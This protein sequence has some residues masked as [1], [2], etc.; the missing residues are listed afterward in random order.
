MSTGN[1][2]AELLAEV[3]EMGFLDPGRYREAFKK[4]PDDAEAQLLASFRTMGPEARQL[5][6]EW[7]HD[8]KCVEAI[9]PLMRYVFDSRDSPAQDGPRRRA[10]EAIRAL[11]EHVS[12][13]KLQAFA[14]DMSTDS[15]AFVREEVLLILGKLGGRRSAEVIQRA[16]DDKEPKVRQRARLLM[17]ELP[18]MATWPDPRLQEMSSERVL[19][20]VRRTRN[21]V[22]RRELLHFLWCREDGRPHLEQLLKEGGRLAR[23]VLHVLGRAAEPEAREVVAN[24]LA[25]LPEGLN[26][27][28]A[29]NQHIIKLGEVENVVG[30]R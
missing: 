17:S 29:L 19:A 14:L 6:V 20:E 15:D 9:V 27:V 2:T 12:P 26:H 10:M 23:D 4:L 1:K 28:L 11:S 8:R 16:L 25:Y 3:E 21:A 7:F 5:T 22:E 30:S 13:G 24:Y 18:D